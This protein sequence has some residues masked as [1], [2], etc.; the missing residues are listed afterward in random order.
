MS[1]T[2]W[3][4]KE[5]SDFLNICK[6]H[7]ILNIL[8]KMKSKNYRLTDVFHNIKSDMSNLGHDKSIYQ[9]ALK[10]KK[11]KKRYNEALNNPKIRQRFEYF[12]KMEEL[13]KQNNDNNKNNNN[14]ISSNNDNNNGSLYQQTINIDEMPNHYLHNYYKTPEIFD[15]LPYDDHMVNLNAAIAD[16]NYDLTTFYGIEGI[17]S[18]NQQPQQINNESKKCD[19]ENEEA[20]NSK[21][22]NL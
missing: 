3:S 14:I 5:I 6:N 7:N 18:S 10:L 19:K 17:G 16:H 1:S 4:N 22:L 2:R 20:K 11:L 9:M 8:K 15:D 12:D 13:E 21:G